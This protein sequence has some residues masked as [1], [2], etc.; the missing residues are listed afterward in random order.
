MWK[1]DRSSCEEGLCENETREKW[2]NRQLHKWHF[3][4]CSWH[5]LLNPC[6]D[7]QII[8]SPWDCIQ[9]DPSLCISSPLQSGQK[10]P[11]L[12]K[13]Y[14]AIAGAFQLL[15]LF[16]YTILE[17]WGDTMVSDTLQF[18]YKEGLSTTQCTWLVNEVSNYFIMR[19][20]TICGAPVSYTHLTLPTKRIV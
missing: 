19:G 15:K 8:L 14:R 10:N 1:G 13:S 18:S 3:S 2:R 20:G 6:W 4:E 12:F 11:E 9:A 16:E 5:S 17:V 7:L